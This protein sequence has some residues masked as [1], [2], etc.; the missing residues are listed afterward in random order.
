MN[1]QELHQIIEENNALK[2]LLK[3]FQEA[4]KSDDEADYVWHCDCCGTRLSDE[5]SKKREELLDKAVNVL[6]Y[7]IYNE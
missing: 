1:E 3:D 2:A 4:L 6:E 7:G 5:F